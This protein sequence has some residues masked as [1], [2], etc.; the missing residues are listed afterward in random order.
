VKRSEA[1]PIDQGTE[2][3]GTDRENN[4]CVIGAY[5]NNLV[6]VWAVRIAVK[7][8]GSQPKLLSSI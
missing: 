1:N 6:R 8:T 3:R 7:L 2:V 5:P 4:Y